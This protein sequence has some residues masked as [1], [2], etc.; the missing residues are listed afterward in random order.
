MDSE[1]NENSISEDASIA[2]TSTEGQQLVPERKRPKIQVK[3][4]MS[5]G[6]NVSANKIYY[7]S[8]IY[9]I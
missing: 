1:E 9:R 2:N 4:N 5:C 6:V 8:Y 3:P 7:F